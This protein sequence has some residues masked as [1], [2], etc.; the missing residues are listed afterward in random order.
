MGFC[1]GD[2]V[3]ASTNLL[4][5]ERIVV[6]H[7]VRGVIEGMD[8][9]AGRMNVRFQQRCDGNA[10]LLAVLP[11]EVVKPGPYAGGYVVAQRVEAAMDLFAD[12]TLLVRQGTGGTVYGPYND[13]RLVVRFDQRQDGQSADAGLNVMPQEVRPA[14]A[15]QRAD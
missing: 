11:F 6:G 7:G 14:A 1:M 9:V 4:V 2:D 13:V 12:Q 3:A 5:G 8:A 10:G 15:N